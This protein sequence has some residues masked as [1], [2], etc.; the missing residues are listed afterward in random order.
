[1]IAGVIGLLILRFYK[2]SKE[3]E[4]KKVYNMVEQIIGKSYVQHVIHYQSE[5]RTH[6]LKASSHY[7]QALN[8]V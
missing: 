7:M 8:I 6:F 4:Q 1:V 2:R 3:E 5:L